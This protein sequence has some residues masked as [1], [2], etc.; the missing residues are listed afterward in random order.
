MSARAPLEGEQGFIP[1]KTFWG[2]KNLQAF[3][4]EKVATKTETDCAEN[5]VNTSC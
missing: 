1:T 4:E 2:P 3:K 5:P